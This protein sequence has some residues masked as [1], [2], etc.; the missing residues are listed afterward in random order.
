M[1]LAG[2]KLLAL[3]DQDWLHITMDVLRCFESLCALEFFDS[4][5]EH[6]EDVSVENTPKYQ[7][8][9]SLFL[10]VSNSEQTAVVLDRLVLDQGWILHRCDI[11]G[12]S[13][14]HLNSLPTLHQLNVLQ[15]V[16]DRLTRLSPFHNHAPFG[17]LELFGLA[18]LN[19]LATLVSGSFF[20]DSELL[21]HDSQ[22]SGRLHIDA[23]GG[24]NSSFLRGL[25]SLCLRCDFFN[26]YFFSLF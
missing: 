10:M 25:C 6:I 15:Q 2:L 26:H 19:D 23:L 3:E 5:F 17:I 9:W 18:F 22:R 4:H 12:V 8:V 20:A 7:V 1:C 14:K 13:D 16:V 11:V 24:G 21:G